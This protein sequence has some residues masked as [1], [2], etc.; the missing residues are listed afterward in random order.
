MFPILNPPSH[1]PPH[2]ISLGHSS[3]PVPSFL[4]PTSNLD[5]RFVSYMILYM[6]QCHSPKSSA[7]PSPTESKRLFYTSVSLLLSP[8]Q[9]CTTKETISK[10]KRQPSEWEKIIANEA[11][12]KQVIS[13]IYKQLLQ[14]NCRKI[15]EPIKKWAKELNRHFTSLLSFLCTKIFLHAC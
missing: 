15:N 9:G 3:A 5:W 8:I 6:F 1:L 2:T 10:V 12:N 13:K 7:P 14:L 4:Y 11:T